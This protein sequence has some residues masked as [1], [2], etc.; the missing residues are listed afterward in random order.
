VGGVGGVGGGLNG[1][2]G[3]FGATGFSPLL[4]QAPSLLD[5][6]IARLREGGGFQPA[7]RGGGSGGKPA[8]AKIQA[9]AQN[10]AAAR[11]PPAIKP[12]R[13]KQ[14]TGGTPASSIAALREQQRAEDDATAAEV[15]SLLDDGRAAQSA[16]MSGAARMYYRQAIQHASGDL[17]LQAEEALR[18]LGD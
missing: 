8:A 15:R 9:P 2:A 14:S 17:K 3:Q 16:G 1:V 6:R 7:Q 13:A 11:H 10:P 18:S 5:E 12:A 4:A